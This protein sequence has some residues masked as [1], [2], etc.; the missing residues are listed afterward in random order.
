MTAHLKIQDI[1][2]GFMGIGAITACLVLCAMVI[3]L[4]VWR[5]LGPVL[6]SELG[7]L[8]RTFRKTPRA[9]SPY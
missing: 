2:M 1:N 3:V 6:P 5:Y 9:T 7:K 4:L 8:I